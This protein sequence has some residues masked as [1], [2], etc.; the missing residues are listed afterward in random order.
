VAYQWAWDTLPALMFDWDYRTKSGASRRA[1]RPVSTL[2]RSLRALRC[3]LAQVAL[4]G[5]VACSEQATE[6]QRPEFGD[7]LRFDTA[8]AAPRSTI[9]DR[10]ADAERIEAPALTSEPAERRAAVP[11]S[12]E[13]FELRVRDDGRAWH[14]RLRR[15]WTNHDRA[16]FRK[17]VVMVARELGAD[18][19]LLTLWALRESTYNPYAIHVLNPDVEAS[20]TAW[21]RHRWDPERAAELEAQMAELGARDPGFWAAK[22]ELSRISRFRTNP[23]FNSLINYDQVMSDGARIPQRRSAWGY[24]YGPFGFNPTYFL[25]IWDADAPPWVFCNDDG[26]AAIVTAVWAAR[27]HQR[28]CEGL[29]YGA[30]N[31]VVNRRFSSGHCAE[32]PERAA[33]FLT[34]A[35]SR[36]IDPAARAK[37]GSRW[38]ADTS[39]RGE[40]L[41]HLRARAA[42][43]GLLQPSPP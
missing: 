38:P 31:E 26:L 5:L 7:F 33:K 27:A 14:R 43:E 21:R 39:D 12:C 28:E 1:A 36:G 18:P 13:R 30:S 2:D 3:G 17:L 35:R 29:G 42:E 10:L 20:T 8:L 32:R 37:L 25:P 19:K 11:Y 15:S 23:H 40:L 34:R 41:D 22:A 4:L 16:N 24:G 9:G 6:M